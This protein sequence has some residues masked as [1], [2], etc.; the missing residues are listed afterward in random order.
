[1]SPLT[2]HHVT[3]HFGGVTALH[4]F[5]LEA[6]E[7]ETLGL[8]GPNGSG[9]TTFF[10][11]VSGLIR[12]DEGSIR[13]D[14]AELTRL[15]PPAIA[16]LGVAR[17]FQISRPLSGLTVVENLLPGL[18]FGSERP[19]PGTARHRAMKLLELVDLDRKAEW[20]AHDLTLWETR[21]LELARALGVGSRLLLLDEIFAGLGPADVPHTVELIRRIRREIATT[22]LLVEHV[23]V[24]TMA[25]CDRIVVIANGE[26]V[27][28]GQPNE[29]VRHPKVLEVY[30]GSKEVPDAE[31]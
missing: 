30:L 20:V 25:L 19:P 27:T 5:E 13:F 3:K 21:R 16:R 26:V 7:G 4:G 2:A 6:R 24:A 18:A 23:M 31:S 17:T 28:E 9:K 15:S 12:P 11:L 10:N 29:V 22:V 14:G 8:I 1:M